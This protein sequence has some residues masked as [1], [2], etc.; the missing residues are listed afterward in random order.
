MRLGVKVVMAAGVG[1]AALAGVVGL[2]SPALGKGVA[3]LTI[4]G[5]GIEL[6][7]PIE[8]SGRTHP[9]EWEGLNAGSGIQEAVPDVGKSA[10]APEIGPEHLGP[11]L[12]LTWHVMTGPNELT[13]IRQD[14]YLYA[15]RGPLTYTAPGQPIWDSVTRGGWYRAPE[16][17]R[18]ALA[19]A[20]VP[21]I[22][23][24]QAS[25]TCYERQ[26]VAKAASASKTR[27][28]VE[29]GAPA[30]SSGD[31][32]WLEVAAGVTAAMAVAG[33]SGAVAVRR[34]RARRRERVAPI[35]L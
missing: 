10:L 27:A 23:D 28:A 18:Q 29:A 4:T 16:R 14:L 6:G 5:P 21:I 22:G 3:S 31:S 24:F 32:S 7:S 15:D 11:R 9:D 25:A 33:L 26:I 30:A 2:A 17:L 19:N 13:P 35:A 8:V 20:C 1:A 34:S 12:T